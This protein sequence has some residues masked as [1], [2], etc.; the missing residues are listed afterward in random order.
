MTPRFHQAHKITGRWE[1]AFVDHSRDPGGVTNWGISIR[2]AGSIG[3]DIDGDGRT[4]RADI[5]AL[6]LDQA[7]ELYF[8]HFWQKMRCEEMPFP[9]GLMAYDQGVNF[10][11]GRSIRFVQMTLNEVGHRLKVDGAI[12]PVTLGAINRVQNVEGFVRKL[13]AR[14]EAYYRRL[15]TFDTFGRGWL[16]RTR[17]VR[18]QA[19]AALA[20]RVTDGRESVTAPEHSPMP[21]PAPRAR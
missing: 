6:T 4:T 2:F 17:D 18:D 7:M 19:L 9:I 20:E 15:S 5:V 1:G 10:G 16:N 14:R 12:G 8:D 3:L 13:A 11:P 21:I